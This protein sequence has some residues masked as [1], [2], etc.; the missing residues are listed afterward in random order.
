MMHTLD[1]I[2]NEHLLKKLI[3]SKGNC[4]EVKNLTCENCP[5]FKECCLGFIYSN[6][7]EMHEIKLKMCI[8]KLARIEKGETE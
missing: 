6:R 4:S 3:E 8:E 7:T 5:L 1:S 2:V